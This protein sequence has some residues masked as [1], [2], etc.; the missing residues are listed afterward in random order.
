MGIWSWVWGV[1]LGGECR[2]VGA[3]KDVSGLFEGA[4]EGGGR[5]VAAMKRTR[6]SNIH[7]MVRLSC[8]TIAVK[9]ICVRA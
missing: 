6:V 2:E 1:G 8:V 5:T 3:G 7:C 9:V 4:L